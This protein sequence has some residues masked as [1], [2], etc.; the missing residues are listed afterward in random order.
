MY[1]WLF[2]E[3]EIRE[4]VKIV[5]FVP[6]IFIDGGIYHCDQ[7]EEMRPTMVSEIGEVARGGRTTLAPPRSLIVWFSFSHVNSH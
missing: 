2:L 3:R 7:N 6:E 1:W 4:S 5:S